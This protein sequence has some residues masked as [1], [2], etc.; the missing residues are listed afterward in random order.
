[1]IT[2]QS[3]VRVLGPMGS[4]GRPVGLATSSTTR[5]EASWTATEST[6][7]TQGPTEAE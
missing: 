1:M 2:I 7:L 3:R 4:R 5:P 6:I